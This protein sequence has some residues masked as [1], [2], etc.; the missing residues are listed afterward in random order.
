MPHYKVSL[1]D[2]R[3]G[4]D[5]EHGLAR[6]EH[7]AMRYWHN[8]QPSDTADKEPSTNDYE[9]LGY[10]ISGQV[11]LTVDGQ[12]LILG[13][14]DSYYVPQDAEHVYRVVETLNAVEVTTPP[15]GK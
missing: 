2:T 13:P 12:T 7:S 14:G 15:A 10:V 4:H 1:E 11:E 3:H 9:T 8:E 6:G 5:G